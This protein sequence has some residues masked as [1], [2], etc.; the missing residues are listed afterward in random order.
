MSTVTQTAQAFCRARQEYHQAFRDYFDS[1]V[2]RLDANCFWQLQPVFVHE[3]Y[4]YRFGYGRTNGVEQAANELFRKPF[5]EQFTTFGGPDVPQYTLED[6]V[7]FAKSWREISRQLFDPLLQCT[8]IKSS[9]SY[10]DLLDSLPLAGQVVVDRC[11]P[12]DNHSDD[13]I[14]TY[15]QLRDAVRQSAALKEYP[16]LSP[17]ILNGENYIAMNLF[18]AGRQYFASRASRESDDSE[19]NHGQT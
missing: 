13:A 17:F 16:E 2:E 14:V 4:S 9:D 7:R 10:G 11:L 15:L 6:A 19:V 12:A 3:V 8:E 5:A 18:E 1:Q